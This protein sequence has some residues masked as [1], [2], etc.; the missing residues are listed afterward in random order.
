MLWLRHESSNAWQRGE[1]KHTNKTTTLQRS[2]EY[3]YIGHKSNSHVTT[4]R[5]F[6]LK[7]RATSA[8]LCLAKCY[9]YA[10]FA[11]KLC[12]VEDNDRCFPSHT[13][14]WRILCRGVTDGCYTKITINWTV[15]KSVLDS[16]RTVIYQFETLSVRNSRT[17]CIDKCLG[18]PLGRLYLQPD[19][20]KH[21]ERDATARERERE[22]SI[23][24]YPPDA[25]FQKRS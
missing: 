7:S 9:I 16:L 10:E 14:G 13:S 17:S 1:S 11:L 4:S 3:K 5:L 6:D 23:L 25:E 20:P 8:Q 21:R 18:F 19:E 15:M 2:V 12:V 22:R 24:W